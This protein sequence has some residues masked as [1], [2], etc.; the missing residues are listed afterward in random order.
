MILETACRRDF[1]ATRSPSCSSTFPNERI[2]AEDR[3]AQ[4]R[5]LMAMAR[6]PPDRALFEGE[7]IAQAADA[8]EPP[9]QPVLFGCR[10][11][12]V[13]QAAM[14]NRAVATPSG[15]IGWDIKSES[16]AGTL[17]SLAIRML[18]LND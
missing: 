18:R 4:P 1:Q 14:E 10:R 11:E 2:V 6:P 15:Y 12:R 3:I 7:I 8:S 9:E 17:D 16:D 13:A 5:A